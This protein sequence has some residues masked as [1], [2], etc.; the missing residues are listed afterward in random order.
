MNIYVA[1]S[2]AH[3]D[4]AALV[5]TIAESHK[6]KITFKWWGPESEIRRDWSQNPETRQRA[7][8]L[9][10]TERLAV[11]SADLVVLL[12][13][14]PGRGLGCFIEAGMALAQNTPVWV[15]ETPGGAR[16]RESVFWHLEQVEML[17]I[18]TLVQRLHQTSPSITEGARMDDSDRDEGKET[19]R[20]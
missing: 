2:T 9:A 5:A 17:D 3:C 10:N 16:I 14:P 8:L 19:P 15:V 12:A 4:M 7:R 13:P 11:R 18:N 1:A 20:A 6:H